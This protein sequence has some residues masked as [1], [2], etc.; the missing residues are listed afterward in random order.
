MQAKRSQSRLDYGANKSDE[1]EERRS[2]GARA[3]G[4]LAVRFVHRDRQD[5]R[6]GRP[7]FAGLAL[8]V[9]AFMVLSLLV[10]ATG[11]ARF[12][13]GMGYDAKVGYAVGA[14]FD[15]AE[16]AF[17]VA[18]LAFWSRRSARL[19]RSLRHL[20]W[21][22]LVA[23]S[24]LATH[25]TVTTAI[26]SIERSAAPGRWRCAAATKAELNARSSSSLLP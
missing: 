16:G 2:D 13:I 20:T 9:V 6:I 17:L 10:T 23:F 3:E 26:S 4:S 19:C 12:A 8:L 1:E 21:A 7:T 18:V 22:C 24:S 11:T 5:G 15:L 14:L 25:A